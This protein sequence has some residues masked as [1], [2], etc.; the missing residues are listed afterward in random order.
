[1][2]RVAIILG[3]K[4]YSRVETLEWYRDKY[5]KWQDTIIGVSCYYGFWAWLL[6]RLTNR[7]V[8]YYCIDFYCLEAGEGWLDT[9]FIKAS[10]QLDKFLIK[11]SDD[12]WDIS[13]RINEGRLKYGNYKALSTIVPCCY[14]P[15]YF[16]FNTVHHNTPIFVGLTPYGKDLWEGTIVNINGSL[17]YKQMV[18]EIE[19]SLCGIAVWKDKHNAY[20]GDSGKTKLYLACGIPAITNKWTTLAPLIE[21]NRAGICIDYNQ[22]EFYE[23]VLEIYKN[24]EEYKNN[25]KKMW[26][27]CNAEDVYKEANI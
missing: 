22:K 8:I 14:D 17:P 11:H 23:A 18:W 15:N 1:M 19:R 10:W 3:K 16:S 27:Y 24:Y 6:G 26:R 2:G 21:E 20:Y 12:V 25:V 4:R 7:K 13:E 5:N 9:L